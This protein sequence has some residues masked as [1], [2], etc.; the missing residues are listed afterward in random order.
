MQLCHALPLQGLGFARQSVLPAR[1]SWLVVTSTPRCFLSLPDQSA[2]ICRPSKDDVLFLEHMP[3]FNEP[4]TQQS[5]ARQ[6]VLCIPQ[7]SEISI[8]QYCVRRTL[9]PADSELLLTY[10]S[11]WKGLCA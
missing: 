10:A 11:Y 6:A 5:G 8:A 2:D 3:S 1:A 7:L 9:K 4:V